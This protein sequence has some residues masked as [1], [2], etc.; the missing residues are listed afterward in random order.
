MDEEHK[1]RNCLYYDKFREGIWNRFELTMASQEEKNALIRTI[2]TKWWFCGGQDTYS[3]LHR[4]RDDRGE[5]GSVDDKTLADWARLWKRYFPNEEMPERESACVCDKEGLR[6][7]LFITDGKDVLVIG[8]VCLKQFLPRQAQKMDARRCE[9]CVE[10][11]KNRKDNYCNACR[12]DIK[13]EEKKRVA[14]EYERALMLQQEREAERREQMRREWEEQMRRW[15][16]EREAKE[17]EDREDAERRAR[18]CECGF[19]KHPQFPTCYL[20]HQRKAKEQQAILD[21][22]PLQQQRMFR[23]S[24][25]KPK[26]PQFATCWS[27]RGQ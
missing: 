13:E 22:M 6:Y 11:H 25:G 2:E 5:I 26:K 27:C 12:I 24:C 16:E 18:V 1:H 23:C 15:Q 17:Q 19:E 8:R 3:H 20:C 7:N 21:K 10:P 4:A 14:E 9:R